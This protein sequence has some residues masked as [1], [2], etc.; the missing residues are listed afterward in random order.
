MIAIDLGSNTLRA[1]RYD[2]STAQ[3]EAVFE[4]I[5]TTADKTHKSKT[6]S[7]AAIERII[8]AIKEAKDKLS[9]DGKDAVGVATAAFRL[10][11]NAQEALETI[12]KETGVEF[13]IIDGEIEAKLTTLAVEEAL[14][15]CGMDGKSFMLVDI[16]GGSTEIILQKEGAFVA[17]SFDIGIVTMAQKYRTPQLLA[18]AVHGE[19]QEMREFVRDC[20]YGFARPELFCATAGTP[21]TL[22]A[23]KLG[24]THET[25][26]AQRINGQTITKDEVTKLAHKL[27]RQTPDARAKLVGTGREEFVAAGAAIFTELFSFG[28]FDSC[29]VF[30]DGLREGVAIATCK[31]IF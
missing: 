31:K 19:T 26:D 30:D 17:Q 1:L 7:H 10:A 3:K 15:K 11:K 24:M 23:L 6:I 29:M 22:A 5:V 9:F 4:K 28:G 18:L 21:T 16:G 25:Y 12:R 20:M 8:E 13:R 27:S 2:C 14:K